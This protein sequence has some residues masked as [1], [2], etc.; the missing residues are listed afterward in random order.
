MGKR[1]GKVLHAGKAVCK[2]LIVG[3]V[4]SSWDLKWNQCDG[5]ER[6]RSREEQGLGLG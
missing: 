5:A 1:K 3:R 2:D 4:G 6:E